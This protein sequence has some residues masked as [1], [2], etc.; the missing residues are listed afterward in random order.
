VRRWPGPEK[1][2]RPSFLKKRSKKLLS[3]C[4]ERLWGTV[5]CFF[6]SK[7]KALSYPWRSSHRYPS[8]ARK[9][10]VY[11]R[12]GQRYGHFVPHDRNEMQ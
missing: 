1:Q 5:F 4:D 12:P 8:R 7:K 3:I 9:Q 10:S 6:F 11:S 2:A